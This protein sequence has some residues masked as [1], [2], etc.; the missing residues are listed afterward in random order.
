[1]SAGLIIFLGGHKRYCYKGST[2]LYHQTSLETRQKLDGF[3]RLGIWCDKL[4]K[5]ID[6]FVIEN[7]KITQ[8]Q[9]ND[10]NEK[11]HDWYISAE[12]ALQLGIVD[13]IL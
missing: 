8:E 1:M 12:E 7:T 3:K 5:E 2:F 4:E 10:T 11:N 9:I 13:E 6:D